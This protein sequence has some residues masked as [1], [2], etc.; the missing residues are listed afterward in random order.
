MGYGPVVIK[1]KGA[2][3]PIPLG[4]PDTNIAAIGAACIEQVALDAYTGDDPRYQGMN[5]L[6]ATVTSLGDDAPHNAQA[7]T[8]FLDRVLGKPKQRVDSTN[9]NVSLLGFLESVTP[10]EALDVTPPPEEEFFQ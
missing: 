2:A 3:C 5:R 6:E 7:R 1:P 4:K 8:E 10:P 9:V